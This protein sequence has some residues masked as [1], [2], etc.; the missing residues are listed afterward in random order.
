MD[1][2]SLLNG[3]C[4]LAFK[5]LND[6]PSDRPAIVPPLEINKCRVLVDKNILAYDLT[7]NVPSW[8]CL[9]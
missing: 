2:V 6:D 5:V 1:Y 7:D 3:R 9:N 8:R 4:T